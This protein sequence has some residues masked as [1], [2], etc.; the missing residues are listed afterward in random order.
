[1]YRYPTANHMILIPH[2]ALGNHS[3]ACQRELSDQGAACERVSPN[4]CQRDPSDQ[5]AACERV[6]PND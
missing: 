5:G 4:A 2:V 6:R 1:M 3:N